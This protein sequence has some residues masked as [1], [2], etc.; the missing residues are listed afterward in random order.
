[1]GAVANSLAVWLLA[2]ADL[3]RAVGVGIDP[4]LSWHWLSKRILWGGLFALAY[5]FLRR[6]V[7][8]PVRAGLVL[9]LLPSAAQLL[10]FAPRDGQG[11]LAL[12]QGLLAPL[13]VLLANA[14]W[15]FV[16]ARTAVASGGG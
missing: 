2:R 11:F 8:S 10:Y 6:A 1:V 4:T 13:V 12:D 9:S 3:L 15:G 14:L 7:P 5:P 16:L